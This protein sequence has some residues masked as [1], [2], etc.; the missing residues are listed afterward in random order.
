MRRSAAQLHALAKVERAIRATDHHPRRKYLR[1]YTEAYTQYSKVLK[2]EQLA[3]EF[4]RADIL[5]VGDYH[6]LP[7]CQQFAAK[8]VETLRAAGEQVVLGLEMI[9]ARD[10]KIVDEWQRGG[11]TDNGLRQ[12]IRHDQEWGYDW[13]PTRELLARAR[14]AGALIRGLDCLPRGDLRRIARRDRHA[15]LEIAEIRFDHP[16]AKIVVL[17]GESHLA[18]QH[19]PKLVRA[20]LPGARVLTLLQNVD[21]LYWQA[22]GEPGEAVRAVRVDGE[23][24][25]VFNAT[26]LEKYER[27]RLCIERWRQE[28]PGAPDVAPTFHNLV[29]ALLQFLNLDEEAAFRKARFES[30][31][32]PSVISVEDGNDLSGVLEGPQRAVLTAG[33]AMRQAKMSDADVRAIGE[34][35]RQAGCCYLPSLNTVLVRKFEIGGAAEEAARFVCCAAWGEIGLPGGEGSRERAFYRACLQNALVEFGS[36][37]LCPGRESVRDYDIYA[38]YGEKDQQAESGLGLTYREYV[39]LIDFV[40]LHRDFERN[41]REYRVLPKLI[42]EGR[43]YSAEKF[44]FATEWLGRLLGMELYEAYLRGSVT[45]RSVSRLFR[46]RAEKPKAAYFQ[47]ARLSRRR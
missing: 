14:Q 32:L 44:A 6:A 28:R 10:Q 45:K 42:R 11:I 46:R 8:L 36:R 2:P 34:R 29:H 31:L 27:Y 38:L 35:L 33:P 23:T 25:C 16:D 5:L 21:A 13:E 4:A 1:D 43:G 18:P 20:V 41:A 47:L 15:A 9:F 26:P 39:R 19:L 30:E 24:V 12:K 22:S 37:V 3:A 7:N 17:F 40:V